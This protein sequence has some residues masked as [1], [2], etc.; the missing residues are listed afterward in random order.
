MSS[1]HGDDQATRPGYSDASVAT[2]VA[3]GRRTRDQ[4]PPDRLRLILAWVA[5]VGILASVLVMI[6][7]SVAGPSLSVV[8]LPRPAAGPPWWIWLHPGAAQ[9]TFALFAAVAAGGI[10]VI[11]GLLAVARGARPPARVIVAFA[12][13]VVGV[14][15]VL[16]AAGSTDILDYAANGRMAATG[17]SP[18]VMTPLELKKSGDPVGQWIPP[19]WET[20]VSVYG[21]VA[22]AEE[23]AAAKLGGTSMARITFWLKLWNSIAFGLIVLLLDRTLRSDPAR[24]LR[25]HLLWTANP[26]LLWEIVASGHIDGLAAAFGLLGILVLRARP[27]PDESAERPRLAGFLL[28]GLFIGVAAAIKIP[29]A[30]FGVGV[31]WAALTGL[32]RSAGRAVGRTVAE[33]AAAAAGFLVV[34]A[35]VYAAAGHPA[36]SVLIS[37]GPATTWDTMYQIFYRPFGYKA[38]G[39]FLVPPHLTAIAAVAFFAVAILAFLR[40]PDG[41]PQ[42]PAL[43]P[44]LAI[45]LAWLLVWSYQRPWYDVMAIVLLA[46]Y[47]ASRLDWLVLLRLIL[48]APVYLPGVPGPTPAWVT[49]AI[50]VVGEVIAP[51]ARLLA[52]LAFIA[53]CILGWWGWREPGQPVPRPLV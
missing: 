52:A 25:G 45:S 17:H 23:W 2:P 27:G 38:F 43:S 5:A 49:D 24:R 12:V 44:A 22:T 9:V 1:A 50:N 7:V 16:P 42:L 15:T 4:P 13:L 40:F 26:L 39:A 6:A 46:V 35:P 47:P 3:P 51:W 34:L 20:N 21:P 19:T 14:L 36:V 29:F 31:I 33:L 37:R 28:A 8:S 32:G 30:A 10:G 53:L 48:T 41:T 11:A 18:Y